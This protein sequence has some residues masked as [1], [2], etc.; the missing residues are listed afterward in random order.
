MAFTSCAFVFFFI[1][2]VAAV[3]LFPQGGRAWVILT[4]NAVFCAFSGLAG[5]IS[6]A[7]TCVSAWYFGLRIDRQA[8]R[9][10]ILRAEEGLDDDARAK[11]LK[12]VGASK[13]RWLILCVA[14]N[15]V[16]LGAAKY[17]GFILE[18][19]GSV[20][21]IPAP[22]THILFPLGISFYTFKAIAYITDV[23][24]NPK[25]GAADKKLVQVAAFISFFPE[26]VQGPISRYGALENT[27]FNPRPLSPVEYAAFTRRILW[28]F[29]KKLV[30]ADRLMP[31]LFAL[32]EISGDGNG[33]YAA[34][35]ALVYAVTL[36]AD[37]TAGIDI[38]IGI[39]GLMGVR[40]A[41]NFN[42]PFFARSISDYWRRWHITMGTWFRDYLLYPLS[43][44]RFMLALQ[45]SCRG[46]FGAAAARHIH[47]AAVT[48]TMW[49]CVGLW[50]GASWNFIVWGL[51]NGAV[52]VVTQ[53]LEPLYGRFHSRFGFTQ[54]SGYAAFQVVRTFLMMAFIHT[55]DIYT[56]VGA[57][58]RAFLSI[59]SNFDIYAVAAN[60][61]AVLGLTV[62]DCVVAGSGT[63]LMVATGIAVR[64]G[65]GK[66]PDLKTCLA[67]SVMLLVATLVFG[68]YGIGYD[69]QQFIYN[70]F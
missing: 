38:T 55:F 34:L 66:E 27:F 15:L 39:A 53:E 58:V 68:C 69:A 7:F 4:A 29:F 18:G 28:G 17:T 19:V 41:E 46:L 61:I 16:V 62:S 9:R 43:A 6:I 2:S 30:I 21:S 26:V 14:L 64:R 60:G 1:I 49:F 40:L 22:E 45:R 25:P 56:S 48:M 13:R 36:Y 67:H 31:A 70:R 8:E 52:F 44:S 20:F 10:A 63:A 57:T 54:R 23:Y 32:P 24:R 3:R 42:S 11:G 33:A 65:A 51:V 59:F 50:H 5:C 37:F 47:A 12:R 35:A